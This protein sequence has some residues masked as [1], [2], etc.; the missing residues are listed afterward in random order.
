LIVF[1][2]EPSPGRVKTRLQPRLGEWGA[3]R[4]HARLTR[5]TLR[6]ARRAGFDTVELHGAPRARSAF[7]LFCRK[8]FQVTLKAQRGTDLGERMFCALAEGLRRHRVVV[9]IGSDCPVL[10]P[11]DLRR[12]QRLLRGA[13]DVVLAPAEDGGYALVAATRMSP[14]LFE[15]VS[16]G[17]VSVYAETASR[18]NAAGYRWR[19]LRTVWDVDRPEDLERLSSSFGG[20]PRLYAEAAITRTKMKR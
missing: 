8:E 9:L 5:G 17:T 19:A 11:Q 4:L 18:L 12:A 6:A 7:F 16:W 3:A 14:D 2:R 20:S 15:G 1:A 10:R 13:C